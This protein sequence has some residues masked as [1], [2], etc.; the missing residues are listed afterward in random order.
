MDHELFDPGQF[1]A[2]LAAA[3]NPTRAFKKAL[4]HAD[5]VLQARFEGQRD[6]HKLIHDRAWLTDHQLFGPPAF[7][8]HDSKGTEVTQA[9]IQGE[10]KRATFLEHLQRLKA[11][12]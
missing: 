2:D 11:A 1:S 5:D 4:Q 7:L 12:N 3:R 10:V 8:F 9:R 6:I